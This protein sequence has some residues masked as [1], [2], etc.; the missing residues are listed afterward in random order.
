MPACVPTLPPTL[1]LVANQAW[2]L[3]N[4]RAGL[5][6]A[7]LADGFRIVA[8][9]PAEPAMSRLLCE[10]GC[11]FIEIPLEAKSLAP[12]AEVRTFMALLRLFRRERP[13]AVLSWTIK[14]NLWSS[15]AARILGI[16]AIANV[17]GLGIAYDASALL[18]RVA[19]VLY[20]IC[21]ARACTV[22]FQNEADEDALVGTGL[23][24]TDQARRLPGSGVDPAHFRP[25]SL[26]RPSSRLY[27]LLARMLAP[28]GIREFVEAARIIRRE[29]ND[30]RFALLGFVDVNNPTAITKAEI[31]GWVEEGVIEYHAPVGDVRPW[32]EDA[33]AVVL[34]SYY[35]EGL[36]RAL[37]EAAAMARPII[38]TDWPGCRE[39]VLPGKTGLLVPPHDG[40]ALASAIGQMASFDEPTWQAWGKAARVRIELEFAESVVIERYRAA[41][42]D[43][44]V[45]SPRNQ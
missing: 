25:A 13:R 31:D 20:R 36:S 45:T 32:L 18:R 26:R 35:R 34:P 11:E 12:W 24:R 22:F 37:L 38:T 8:V 30:L 44:G 17:S 9:S 27:L 41:L 1:V 23:L 42:A 3:V 21:F 10:M 15:L 28:K 5:I 29:R 39:A 16:P 43:A 6:Q 33:E 2:N 7:L 19:S 4:Y 14:A 40:S